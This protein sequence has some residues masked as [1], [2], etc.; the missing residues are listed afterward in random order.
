MGVYTTY[1]LQYN[2][3]II[4]FNIYKIYYNTYYKKI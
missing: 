4:K 1:Y 3:K 2:T